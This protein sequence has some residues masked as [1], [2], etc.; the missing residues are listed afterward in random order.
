[1]LGQLA[2]IAKGGEAVADV[3]KLFP[4]TVEDGAV[5]RAKL[6]AEVFGKD[7]ALARL[8]AILHPLVRRQQSRFL[9][10]TSGRRA[11]LVVLDIPLLFE[12]KGEDHCDLV[13][14]VSV[15]PFLQRARILSRPGMD[16]KKMRAILA[17]Q[18]PDGEK[19]RRADCIINTGLDRQQSLRQVRNIVTVAGNMTGT[20][21]PPVKPR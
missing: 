14:V 4:G 12:T 7:D 18:V 19:R 5:M 6:G 15:S 17:R 11:P 21:W 9:K 2:A 20:H 8:E 13:A 1:M 10:I 3:A 16:A